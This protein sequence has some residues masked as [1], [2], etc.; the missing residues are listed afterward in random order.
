[1][2]N[3][4]IQEDVQILYS[5]APQSAVNTPITVGASF[6]SALVD[7][8]PPTFP[9]PQFVDD[10]DQVG[11]GSEFPR[12]VRLYRW[13]IGFSLGMKLNTELA[14]V[15]IAR[16]LGGTITNTVVT[17]TTS[18]DHLVIMQKRSQGRIPKATTFLLP[19][20]GAADFLLADIFVNSFTISQ[21][22][23][24]MPTVQFQLVGTGLHAKPHGVTSLPNPI[25]DTPVH[26]YF[27]GAALGFVLN[28]GS[29]RDLSSDGR[30]LSWSLDFQN[31]IV[32]SNRVGDSFM[33]A[34][35]LASGAYSKNVIHGKRRTVLNYRDTLGDTLNQWSWLINTTALTGIALLNKGMDKI[36]VTDR[37]ELEMRVPIGQLN[38]LGGTQD[39]NILALDNGILALKDVTSE[40]LLTARGR[41]DQATLT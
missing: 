36:N 15:L 12:W 24:A 37:Y 1:M 31:N 7:A 18:W 23:D 5:S 38:A 10:S 6:K 35:D 8:F 25:T 39:N 29:V 13:G 9:T 32:I 14:L 17:A 4:Y 22:G 19:L 40:G 30:N 41:N 26:H 20:I 2:G 21:T 27:H 16:A 34:G 11:D 3:E 33:T 28:D